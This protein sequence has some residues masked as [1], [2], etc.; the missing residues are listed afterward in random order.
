MTLFLPNG[1]DV[2]YDNQKEAYFDQLIA[3]VIGTYVKDN[4]QQLT[5]SIARNVMQK[6]VN[7]IN[8]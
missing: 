8:D 7:D 3:L 5:L 6:D 1:I 4:D 2:A